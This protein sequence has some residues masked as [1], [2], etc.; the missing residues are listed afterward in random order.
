[1][2]QLTFDRDFC[3]RIILGERKFALG[4]AA[5]DHDMSVKIQQMFN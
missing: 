1:M 3:R 5:V 2:F 4:R